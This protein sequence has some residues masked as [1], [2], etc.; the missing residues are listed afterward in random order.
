MFIGTPIFGA[1]TCTINNLGYVICGDD[2]DLGYYRHNEMYRYNATSNSWAYVSSLPADGR[3]DA[4]GF[5]INNKFYVGTGNDNNYME[6]FDWWEYD[7]ANGMWTQKAAF[8][9]SPRSQAVGWSVGGKGYLGTGG[10]ADVT[11]FWQ[12]DPVTNSWQQVNDFP[13]QG[14]ENAQS[15]VIG[16]KGYLVCGTSGVNYADIW[17]FD[18]LHIV[19]LQEQH[20]NDLTIYPTIVESEYHVVLQENGKHSIELFDLS[21]KCVWSSTFEG[22]TFDGERNSITSGTYL[23]CVDRISNQPEQMKIVFR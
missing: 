22:T 7:P 6:D 17:E 5:A 9:G 23:I 11:D 20:A 12:Y 15:F 10:L 16:N 18:P 21:G 1:S 3:R 8:A 19:G 2:W 14:R 13:G 4:V